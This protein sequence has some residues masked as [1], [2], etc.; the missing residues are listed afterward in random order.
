[1]A[2]R[3]AAASPAVRVATMAWCRWAVI[4]RSSGSVRR[5]G[6]TMAG[7]CQNASVSW[8]SRS[9][10]TTCFAAYHRYGGDKDVRVYEFNDHEG[11]EA[12]HQREQLTWLR[13]ILGG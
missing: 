6:A 3:S 13:G 8:T 4:T 2:E 1:M 11:G 9:L 7:T 5:V 12:A 10:P